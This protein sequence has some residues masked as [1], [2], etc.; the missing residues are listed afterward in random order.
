MALQ[1]AQEAGATKKAC[2]ALC[3]QAMELS[4]GSTTPPPQTHEFTGNPDTEA[5]DDM[6]T[7]LAE[8]KT[9]GQL[10]GVITVEQAKRW[11]R[12]R[13]QRGA[14]AAATLASLSRMRNAR[15]H[16]KAQQLV[17]EVKLI[18]VHTNTSAQAIASGEANSPEGRHG[19]RPLDWQ[20]FEVLQAR[21]AQLE[22]KLGA[23]STTG[24]QPA[25]EPAPEPPKDGAP[26]DKADEIGEITDENSTGDDLEINKVDGEITDE[27]ST[28]DDFPEEKPTESQAD[29]LSTRSSTGETSTC[30][31]G[32][33]L[34]STRERSTTWTSTTTR[35]SCEKMCSTGECR[36]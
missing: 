27:N 14:K 1:A 36:N 33:T 35:L 32:Q 31:L 7:V 4:R 12:E 11:L 34:F 24:K 29:V 21:V 28:G 22:I 26:S 20:A 18:A 6:E 10:Q 16:P 23:S 15:A 17:A 25:E 8:I 19:D 2:R 3:W 5:L 30:S 9:A 13:G